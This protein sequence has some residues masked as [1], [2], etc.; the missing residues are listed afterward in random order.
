MSL[1]EVRQNEYMC[2]I[3]FAN[4]LLYN[5]YRLQIRLSIHFG[6]NENEEEKL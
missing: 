3:S 4:N 1:F 6:R 2:F 5:F